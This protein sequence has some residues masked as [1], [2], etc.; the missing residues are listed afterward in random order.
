LKLASCKN[1]IIIT[2]RVSHK[3]YE[4]LFLHPTWPQCG[5]VWNLTDKWYWRKSHADLNYI[6]QGPSE[7]QKSIG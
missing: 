5:S 6:S 1:C 2:W 7:D 4:L 3:Y